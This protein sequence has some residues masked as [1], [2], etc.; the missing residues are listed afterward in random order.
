MLKEQGHHMSEQGVKLIDLILSQMNN[1]RLSTNSSQPAID[2]A[3][4]LAEITKLLSGPSN[5][6]LRN[7]RK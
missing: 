2:R 4:L 7:G 6:E 1:N 5:F 3:L